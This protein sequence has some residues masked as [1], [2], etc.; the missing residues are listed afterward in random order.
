M[1]ISKK[2]LAWILGGVVVLALVGGALRVGFI[3]GSANPQTILVK[4]ITNIGD[5]DVKA[6]FG[7]FWQSWKFIANDFYT[8]STTLDEQKMVYGAARGLVDSL[9]DPH[10]NFFPPVE[11]K[12]F[13]EDIKGEFG[14]I[15]AEIGIRNN[16]LVIVAP[17]KDSPAEH[18]GLKAADQILKINGE[19][20]AGINI[21]EAVTKI[22]G[23]IGTPVKLLIFRDE[24]KEPKEITITR[25]TIRPP[26]AKTEI[27]PGGIAHISLYSFSENSASA[28]Y[29]EAIGAL[30]AGAQD[31][32]LDLRNNPGG[33][34]ESAVDIAGMFL[35]RG[36]LV[37]SEKSRAGVE[38]LHR[39][40]GNELL[41]DIPVVIL[42]NEGSA[43][44]SEILAGALRDDRDI[45]LVGEKTYG[46]GSVQELKT[47]SGGAT[48]K[49]TIAHWFT[50]KGAAIEK[51]GLTPDVEAKLTD[52]DI[53]AK[54]DTQLDKA[55]ETL[56]K[57]LE[58]RE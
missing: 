56:K 37:V 42:V 30:T 8:G 25:A 2:I 33:Y 13:E 5:D 19:D 48:L 50:P 29:K 20:T 58:N 53:A 36:S 18:A 17:L 45:K 1:N 26:I 21:N 35:E 40:E 15:G 46:K 11:A 47:L 28:F 16:Q 41:K 12:K 27:L 31:I 7:V 6:D 22:R 52:A 9:G 39:A 44:A 34:L 43:S 57:E 32:V 54:K 38:R 4:G 10:T 51:D 49:L 23:P 3:V 24:W 14:G 55:V